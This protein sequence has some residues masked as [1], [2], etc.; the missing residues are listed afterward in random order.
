MARMEELV[1]LVGSENVSCDDELLNAFSIDESF[2]LPGKAWC[3]VRPGSA[4][5]V[6]QIIKWANDASEPIIPV[7]SPGGPRF[8]GD[9]IPAQGGVV[10]DLSGMDN[11]VNVDRKDRIAI[12]EPGVTFGQL[13]TE[14]RKQGLRALKPLLPRKTKSALAS[15]LERE[16]ITIPREHWDATDPLSCTEIVFGNGDFCRTGSAALPKTIKEQLNAGCKQ[17]QPGGPGLTSLSR[18]VQGAQGTIGV[19]TWASVFCGL[20]PQMEKSF[21]ISSDDIAPLIELTYQL[22][23]HRIGEELFLLNGFHLAGIMADNS[24]DIRKLT[25]VLPAW[26][27]VLNLTGHEYLPDERIKY[28]EDD[29]RSFVFALGLEMVE[30]LHGVSC[31]ALMK[32]MEQPRED[33]YKLRFKGGCQDL[34]FVTTLNRT[35]FFVTEMYKEVLSHQYSSTELGVYIQPTV[36]GCSCHCEFGLMYDPTDKSDQESVKALLMG[37]SNHLARSGAFFN[38]PYWPW[39]DAAFRMDAETTAAL[40]KVKAIFDPNRIMN[41]SKLI[42]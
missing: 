37:A 5:Q 25:A 27:L 10:V 32:E 16:P 21:F 3:V 24:E 34:F 26:L 15:Y 23:R 1:N 31:K 19:V 18:V 42:Y 12:I 30:S 33:Y 22:L 2:V 38:R 39:A 35:P 6:Q 7:S 20:L 8:H 17:L 28:Q 9:T 40:R 41:P 13:E 14:L 29:T 11:V 36:Q 4:E